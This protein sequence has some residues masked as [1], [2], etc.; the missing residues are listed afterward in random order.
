MERHTIDRRRILM[1]S[2]GVFGGLGLTSPW[3]ARL[4]QDPRTLVL[5]QLSGGNDGLSTV[6][7]YGDDAYHGARNLIRHDPA[8]VLRLDEYRGLHPELVRLRER[9]AQG[10]LA[11]VEGVGY[12]EPNRSHFTSFEIW[13]TGDRRGRTSGEGWVGRLCEAVYGEDAD[14]N[15][16]V[17]VGKS[18]PYSL[19]STRHPAASFSAPYGYR[20]VKNGQELRELEERQKKNEGKAPNEA[21]AFLRAK[22]KDAHASSAAIRAAAARYRTPVAYPGDAFADELRTAAALI[23]GGL[24]TRVVSVEL[25]G[26]DT[27]NDQR[28][29]HDSLMSQLDSCLGAFFEDLQ[30]SEAGRQAVVVVFS[31]FGRRVAENGSRG[32]DHGCAGPM[33]VAGGRVKGG[34]YGKH[35]SL[36]ELDEGDLIFTTDFRSVYA[37][38]IEACFDIPHEKV[39][40]STYPSLGLIRPA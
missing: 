3:S 1:G 7:P 27:H 23:A 15:R 14:A 38:A 39:L 12:P 21:L 37:E 35:P 11:I 40:G 2:L 4:A 9:Y 5:V 26:F 16:V 24:G 19:Y 13:H 31:E 10:G 8:G 32:T 22:M 34:L 30:R 36:T 25:S 18:P 33:F 29:R 20:W 28:G 6:I 17:H